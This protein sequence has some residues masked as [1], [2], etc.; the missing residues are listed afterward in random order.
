VVDPEKHIEGLGAGTGSVGPEGTEGVPISSRRTLGLGTR[1]GAEAGAGAGRTRKTL[2]AGAAGS[3][4]KTVDEERRDR[5]K[6]KKT[7][8]MV[9]FCNRHKNLN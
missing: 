4:P 7:S 3:R 6:D 1:T 2:G 9:E 8:F 5:T